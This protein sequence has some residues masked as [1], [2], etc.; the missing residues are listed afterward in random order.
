MMTYIVFTWPKSTRRV[1]RFA[2][3]WASPELELTSEPML[4]KADAGK[5]AAAIGTTVISCKVVLETADRFQR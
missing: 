1:P 4:S 2:R 5:A 3:E